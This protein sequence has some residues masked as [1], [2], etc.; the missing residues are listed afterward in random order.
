VW[1][2]GTV[3]QVGLVAPIALILLRLLVILSKS[4]HRVGMAHGMASPRDGIRDWHASDRLPMY[5]VLAGVGV[6][7]TVTFSV[8]AHGLY[9]FGWRVMGLPK[10]MA[11]SVPIGLDFA[12]LVM[13]AATFLTRHAIWRV[14][15]YMWLG[16]GITIG[17]SV[18]ANRQDAIVRGL[19][20]AGVWSTM[21][22]P[23]VMA[24]MVHVGIIVWRH[25]T[26]GDRRHV[27]Q[28]TPATTPTTAPA[29]AAPVTSPANRVLVTRPAAQSTGAPANPPHATSRLNAGRRGKADRDAI[30]RLKANG[31]TQDQVA[32]QL[33]IGVRTVARYWNGTPAIA[34][35]P[36][37]DGDSEPVHAA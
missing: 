7:L 30:A 35:A 15:S 1:Q 27:E 4:C 2:A 19:S 11:P 17:L 33:G 3:W 6:L 36:S 22:S 14:R 21:A 9:D 8:S 16:F 29:I 26:S 5:T 23:A 25:C 37:P 28:A 24:F 10:W 18:A 13:V 20:R 31:K 12:Q 32:T 34:S